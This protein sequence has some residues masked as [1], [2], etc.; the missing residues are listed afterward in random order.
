MMASSLCPDPLARAPRAV[1]GVFERLYPTP[2][3]LQG[4]IVAILCR[5]TR[6]AVLNDAQRL[7]HFPATPLVTLSWFQGSTAGLVER[8]PV[9]RPFASDVLL[10]GSHYRPVVTWA[11]T[12]GRGGF[13]CL[14]PDAAQ[15][16]FEIEVTALQDRIVSAASVL[17]DRWATFVADLRAAS[18]DAA[19]LA[20]LETHL[21]PRWQVSQGRASPAPTLRQ[22]GRHWVARLALQARD[23]RRSY[24]PRQVERRIKALSGRSLRDWHALVRTEGVFFSARDRFERGET[25]DWATLAIDEGFSDQAHLTR[26][27]KRITCFAPGEFS[28]RFIAD[29]SFWAYRLWV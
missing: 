28:A 12:T 16:L 26:T 8:G 9:W 23:W 29:E 2:P 6:A 13:A 14:T 15:T 4:A 5:D 21:A 1:D 17:G 3:A 18:D 27:V 7:T 19:T 20:A 11:P 25:P 24:S 22:L 10:A